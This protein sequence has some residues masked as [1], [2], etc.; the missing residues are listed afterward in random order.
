MNVTSSDLATVTDTDNLRVNCGVSCLYSHSWIPQVKCLPNILGQ[1][2][3]TE[4]TPAGIKYTKFFSAT[5]DINGIVINCSAKFI[6]TG[7]ERLW[8][9]VDNAPDD[10]QLWKSAPLHVQ[11]KQCLSAEIFYE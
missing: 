5:P 3:E 10:V 6:S 4:E 7:S 11:C 2:E 9:D 8:R 1:T